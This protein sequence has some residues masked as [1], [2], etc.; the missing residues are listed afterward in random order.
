MVKDPLRAPPG[1][2]NLGGAALLRGTGGG[3][4]WEIAD[5]VEYNAAT[6]TA[7]VHTHSGRTLPDVP[8]IKTGP[9]EFEHYKTGTSVVVTYDLGFPAIL[10]CINFTGRPQESIPAPSLTGLDGIGDDN[11]IQSTEG[12]NS[13]KPAHAPSDMSNGDWA[14]VGTFGNHVAVMESGLSLFGSPTAH[15][16]SL[17]LAG[18]MQLIANKLH[19]FTDF[20]KW[21][22]TNDGGKTSFVLRAGSNQSTQTGFDEENW[23]IRVDLGATGD[24]F[25]F[26][27]TEPQGRTLFKLHADPK[28]RVQIYGDGGIDI[29][30]GASNDAEAISDVGTRTTNVRGSEVLDVK[31][32]RSTSVGGV[33]TTNLVSDK[34]TVVG[35]SETRVIEDNQTVSIGGT[36]VEVV[37]G[38]GP[39]EAH[40]GDKALT[41]KIMNGGWMIDIGNPLDGAN[42]GLMAA[43]HLRTALGDITLESGGAMSLSARMP[44][45]V[46]GS[47]IFLGGTSLTPLDGVV[48]GKAI[49]T[50]TGSPQFA[51]GNASK[52]VWAKK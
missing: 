8:Q 27:I 23:T 14:R 41:T 12:S 34:N 16:R 9:G 33:D 5:V 19:T 43:Y 30:S 46:N 42:I 4:K 7:L 26:E 15:L 32:A 37:T 44:V 52:T 25:N 28:G 51:L 24:I 11:P 2:G 31:G 49:D 20:G 3:G 6:H 29:S 21:Q 45:R 1:S 13:Y 36:K 18:V 50:F 17:G 10:G 38:G 39:L 40:P 47:F 35:G 22:T 48:T